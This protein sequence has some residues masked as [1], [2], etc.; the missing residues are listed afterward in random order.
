MKTIETEVVVV[1][2][3][4]AGLTAARDLT[5]SGHDTV[6]LE[7]QDRV[8]GRTLAV[9]AGSD[10]TVDLG[11]CWFSERKKHIIAL[12]D[13]LRIG[14][15]P[16][17]DHGK[18]VLELDGR[19]QSFRA[20]IPILS[21]LTLL[22]IGK[23][24][25]SLNM[26]CGQVPEHAPWLAA[27]ATEWDNA[28]LDDW[29]RNNMGNAKARTLLASLARSIWGAE[30]A[31]VNLLQALA[32]M[33]TVGSV[34]ALTAAS[35]G[36]LSDLFV[37]GAHQISTLLADSL[38]DRVLLSQP[39][40]ALIQSADQ[41]EV[42]S[43]EVTVR[44]RRAVVAIPPALLGDIAF[45]PVLSAD[46]L[47]IVRGLPMGRMAK[48]ALVYPEPFW[49]AAGLS[50]QAGSDRPPVAA[51]FD[52]SP[53]DGA[54]GILVGFVPGDWATQF[55]AMSESDRR[56]GV[57]DAFVRLFGP[58]AADYEHYLEKDWTADPWV[59]GCYFG[60]AERGLVTGPLRHVDAADGLV[61]W[62]GA[63]T[64]WESFGSMDG[65]VAS[66]RRAARQIAAALRGD[67]EPALA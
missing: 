36:L 58:R 57:V 51:T 64:I 44:A 45:D 25:L 39:V 20:G 29:M 35:G 5:A 34:E 17:Y 67:E 10:V 46:R 42:R 31:E 62:A 6:V 7:A 26:M 28:T 13:E 23:A 1:G 27:R 50:G 22:D 11:G 52:V 53:C 48:V 8:G 43:A 40:R 66:G 37:D 16:T 56:A 54:V 33:R 14:G 32:Y 24:R 59:R 38:G 61:H 4:L 18:Q 30:P 9:S 49:R 60:L 15:Y 2:A 65:A 19:V 63:E 21:P 12:A 41:V 55:S 3:G 47:R